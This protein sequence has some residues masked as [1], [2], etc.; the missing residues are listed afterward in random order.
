MVN[1]IG[2]FFGLALA[3]LQ[4][5]PSG[6]SCSRGVLSWILVFGDRKSSPPLSPFLPVTRLIKSQDDL[7]FSSVCESQSSIFA[8]V[9]LNG[10]KKVAS[11]TLFSYSYNAKSFTHII[12]AAR[13]S[14][15]KS[16]QRQHLAF[17]SRRKCSGLCQCSCFRTVFP[18][19]AGFAFQG[20]FGN[21]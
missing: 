7:H 1:R 18:N 6:T 10:L 11:E 20:T 2:V 15:S 13:M 14:S 17:S 9:C 16:F 12:R 19:Q 21:V 5:S 4:I 8:K 3:L